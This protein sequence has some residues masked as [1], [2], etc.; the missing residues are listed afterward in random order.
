MAAFVQFLVVLTLG[1]ASA[2]A[3]A[4]D[5]VVV[6]L[7]ADR[8]VLKVDGETRTLRLGETRDGLTLLG[9]NTREA[10]LRV[11]G[12]EKRLAMGQDPVGP[13]SGYRGAD[14]GGSVVIS[15]NSMGQFTVSGMINGR[16][17]DFLVDTGANSVSM[18][19][20]QA[21]RLGVDYLR[22][23]KPCMS[24]TANGYLRC[25]SVLLNRV[26]VGPITVEA[27]R[28]TVRDLNDDGTPVLLGMSFLERVRMEHDGTRLKLTG[29]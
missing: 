20:G 26:K 27:V 21:A 9:V 29:R 12:E 7:M 8:A 2:V 18:S 19:R 16:V 11:D 23:G 3:Q 5:I 14:D 17:V 28:A 24:Q 13:R 6:G 1:L 10:R 15:S 4:R 22:F 25:W